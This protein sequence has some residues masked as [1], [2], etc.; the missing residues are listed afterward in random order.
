MN[1]SLFHKKCGFIFYNYS[2]LKHGCQFCIKKPLLYN[3]NS[4]KQ[5]ASAL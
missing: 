5:H 4:V 3:G 1:N 2:T